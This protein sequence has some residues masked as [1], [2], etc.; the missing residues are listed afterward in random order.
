MLTVP[1]RKGI[2]RIS[3]DLA[4]FWWIP[5]EI[6]R[7]PE[8]TIRMFGDEHSKNI[9]TNFTQ[10][11]PKYKFIQNKRW[12]VALLPLPSQF[13]EYLKKNELLRRKRRR[14]LDFGL[15]FDTLDPSQHLDE[16]LAINRSVQFRQGAFM[17]SSYLNMEQLTL[18]ATYKPLIYGVFDTNGVLSAYTHTPVCGEVFIFSRLLGHGNDLDKGIMYF[19]IS[20][21]IRQMIECRAK[22]GVPLWAMYDTFFGAGPGLRF[23]KERLGF[24]PHKVR[25]VWED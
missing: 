8:A 20:E 2:K 6:L 22:Q 5:N 24:K 3:M 25:W 13:E 7:L 1:I 9:F 4:R 18:W 21:V 17:E 15:R 12:G 23:F 19:M 11:H 16:I 14:S 10:P